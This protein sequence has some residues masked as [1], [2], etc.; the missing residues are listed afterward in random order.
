MKQYLWLALVLATGAILSLAWAGMLME[1]GDFWLARGGLLGSLVLSWLLARQYSQHDARARQLEQAEASAQ[2]LQSVF[3]NVLEAII[4]MD[5]CG[6]IHSVNR[7]TTEMLGYEVEELVGQNVGILSDR[8]AAAQ[9]QFLGDYLK[10]GQAPVVGRGREVYVRP[11]QG[12]PFPIWLSVTRV[13]SLGFSGFTAVLRDLRTEKEL[14]SEYQKNLQTNQIVIKIL[15]LSLTELSL[16]EKLRQALGAVLGTSWLRIQDSGAIFLTDPDHDPVLRLTVE[17]R[18]APQLRVLCDQVPFGH[19]LCGRAAATQRLQFASCVDC[20]HDNTYEGMR[21]H[22]NY[23]VPFVHGDQTLGVMVLYLAEGHRG[24]LQ[25][26]HFMH[27]VGQ[28]LTGLVVREQMLAHLRR[29]ELRASLAV[30][31]ADLG[32]WDWNIQTNAAF[33]NERW[34][35]MLGYEAAELAGHFDTWATLLHPDDRERVTP[36]LQAHLAGETDYYEA[37]VRLKT[38]KGGWKWVHTQGQVYERDRHGAPLRAAGT[39]RDISELRATQSELRWNLERLEQTE[40][41]AAMGGWTI[42]L[43]DYRLHWS[44]EIFRIHEREDTDAPTIE[45]A[46]RYYVGDARRQIAEAVRAAS[47]EGISFDL[48]LPLRTEKGNLLWVRAL[49]GPEYELGRLVRVSGA[50]LDITERRQKDDQLRQ[51]VEELEQSRARETLQTQALT[52]QAELLVQAKARAEAST[53]AKS[54]FLANMSHEIRTPMN[55]VLGMTN[56]L[57]DSELDHD[58]RDL[59]HTV[60]QSAEALLHIIDDILDFSKIEA[61]KLELKPTEFEFRRL[62]TEFERH[63]RV[64]FSQKRLEFECRIS[65]ALPER[66]V[67]DSG[68]LNQVLVNLV[69]NAIK[70]TPE[71]GQITLTVDLEADEQDLIVVQFGVA[72][73]G[74]GIAPDQQRRIFEAF[75]QADTSATRVFGGT[76]LGLTISGQLVELMG[77]KLAVTSESGQGSLFHFQVK[78]AK[79]G[80]QPA[81]ACDPDEAGEGPGLAPMRVLLAEDNPINQKLALRLLEKGGHQVVL[82]KNGQQALEE[83]ARQS[84]DLVLMDIQMPVMDGVQAVRALRACERGRDLP[85]VAVTAHA[86]AGDREKYLAYGM[87]S[88]VTKPLNSRTLLLAMEEARNSRAARLA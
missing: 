55:G 38:R 71:G 50:F 58:Q 39:H 84:F 52:A 5:D 41:I 51:H 27:A 32:V 74:I 81:P 33:F 23:N 11:K 7:A 22:G 10:T 77:G 83:F 85:V 8:T 40:R 24:S 64:R 46:I 70:F 31:G 61:G 20:R 76:G 63:H 49:G 34:M 60:K 78:F 14:A 62:L 19:C 18:L 6:T 66:V 28:A 35:S 88:Y 2:R 29:T 59:A 37:E 9:D 44:R 86:L 45:E 17:H 57:L 75:S 79:A 56:L 82:A 73:S 26:H 16:E 54:Q 68:R 72:D 15:E 48:E 25:E 43:A 30:K 13:R 80:S 3:E 1:Q 69:G 21:P 47:E 12:R 53:R 87:D 36:I 4:T 42:D 65:P 67:G